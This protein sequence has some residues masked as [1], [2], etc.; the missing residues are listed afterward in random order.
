MAKT[1]R[2]NDNGFS[3]EG[4]SKHSNMKKEERKEFL[5]LKKLKRT[6]RTVDTMRPAW[7]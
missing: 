2:K 3:F 4:Q 5:F 1:I 7:A 6:Q